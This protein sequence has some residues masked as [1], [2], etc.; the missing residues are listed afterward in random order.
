MISIPPL[1][2][3]V[4][5]GILA[6]FTSGVGLPNT[7]ITNWLILALASLPPAG[8]CPTTHKPEFAIGYCTSSVED[9]QKVG[10]KE[11][12]KTSLPDSLK[13]LYANIHLQRCL[14]KQKY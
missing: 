1:G 4:S 8:N 12:L 9:K 7:Q 2:T 6:G 5:K 11:V 3:S 14:G 10:S 13:Y